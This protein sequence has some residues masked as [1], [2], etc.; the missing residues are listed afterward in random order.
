MKVPAL[1]SLIGGKTY[2]LLR[3]LTSPEKP[4]EKNFEDIVKLLKDHLSPKPSVIAERF[5]FNR[6]Q[7]MD[8]E[9]VNEYVA[10][11]RKLAEY[12][13]FGDNLNDTLRDRIELSHCKKP[14]T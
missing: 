9:S 12:C 4:A 8:G 11:L 7:Q 3:D 2:S 10:K 13:E 6:R 14:L 1:S 5:G